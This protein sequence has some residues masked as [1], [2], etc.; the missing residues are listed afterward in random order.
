MF[1]GKTVPN[2][3]WAKEVPCVFYILNRSPINIARNIIPQ[4][5]WSGKHHYVSH[6]RVFGC[7]AYAHVHKEVRSK[8]DYKSEK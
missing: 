2:E 3:C 4:Q 6:I 8:L 1:K 7:I 5:T